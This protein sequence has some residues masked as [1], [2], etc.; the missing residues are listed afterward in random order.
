MQLEASSPDQICLVSRDGQMVR[1]A[2]FSDIYIRLDA[3]YESLIKDRRRS[4]LEQQL[5]QLTGF[6]ANQ[7]PPPVDC[8]ILLPFGGSSGAEKEG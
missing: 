8:Q 1:T 7:K 4:L 2:T 3:S 5:Q 6:L